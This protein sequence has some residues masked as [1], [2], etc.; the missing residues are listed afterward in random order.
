MENYNFVKTSDIEMA[1]KLRSLGYIEI[2][3][4]SSKEFCFINDSG[5]MLFDNN[6]NVVYTNILCL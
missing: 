1:N 6:E 5:K 2:T 4:E 3:E